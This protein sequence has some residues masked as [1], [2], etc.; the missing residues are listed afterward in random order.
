MITYKS[1]IGLELLIPIVLILG[2]TG[3]FMAYEKIWTG[4]AIILAVG[5]FFAHLFLTTY[6]QVDAD[7]L[8]VKCGFL[9]NKTISIETIREIRNTK[10]F[11]SSPALSL[12]RIVVSYGKYDSVI[13]SPE[14]KHEFIDHL[15][16]NNPAI[17][18]ALTEAAPVQGSGQ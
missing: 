7:T 15:R 10:S 4:L 17:N 18:V 5:V 11:I 13:I 8:R 16:S 12:D 9:L 6:Y 2:G 14:K 1:K 3:I